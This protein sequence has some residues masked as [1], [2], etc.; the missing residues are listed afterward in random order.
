MNL[1]RFQIEVYIGFAKYDIL[2]KVTNY[3]GYDAPKVSFAGLD[4]EARLKALKK[5]KVKQNQIIKEEK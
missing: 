1:I 3:F 2:K 5:I 4:P